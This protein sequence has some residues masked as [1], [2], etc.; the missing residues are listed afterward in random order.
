MVNEWSPGEG[1]GLTVADVEAAICERDPEFYVDHQD[2]AQE[3]DGVSHA[4]VRAAIPPGARV[5]WGTHARLPDMKHSWVTFPD[6]T[7]LDATLWSYLPATPVLY[8][9]DGAEYTE[10]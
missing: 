2:W 8:V 10:H 3:C 1:H 9:S 6:G 5:A 4:I 7:V